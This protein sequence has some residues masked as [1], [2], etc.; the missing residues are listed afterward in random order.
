[1]GLPERLW[2]AAIL[3]QEMMSMAESGSL[4]VPDA[5]RATPGYPAMSEGDRQA[6]IRFCEAWRAKQSKPPM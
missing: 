5:V 3:V 2:D 4:T 6:L 1:M